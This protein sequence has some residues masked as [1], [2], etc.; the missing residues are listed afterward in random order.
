MNSLI[1]KV[2]PQWKLSYKLFKEEY[3]YYPLVNISPFPTL[4]RLK[5]FICVFHR[6]LTVVSKCT[7]DL[8]FAFAFPFT[9]DEIYYF[10]IDY[11]ETKRMNGYK[12][13]LRVISFPPKE[14]KQFPRET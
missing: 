12:E 1:D 6:F 7:V 5:D 8:D 9:I 13:V 3:G 11:N 14:I 10:L 4:V 2:K